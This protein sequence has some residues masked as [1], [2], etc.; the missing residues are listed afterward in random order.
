MEDRAGRH[1]RLASARRAH[2][3]LPLPDPPALAA[4]ALRADEAIGPTQLLQ[5]R[6]A[7]AVVS[8]PVAELLKGPRVV[9][10]AL[11]I[12][13]RHSPTLLH[14]SRYAE[15]AF[16]HQRW[17][18]RGSHRRADPR[19]ARRPRPRRRRTGSTGPA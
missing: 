19:P 6:H 12:C 17:G 1:R 4:V 14:S 5:E 15:H 13:R 16:E 9:D 11:R 2:P 7:I 18:P 10:A 8:E 3:H